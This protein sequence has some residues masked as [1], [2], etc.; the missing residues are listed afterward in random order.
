MK[1]NASVAKQASRLFDLDGTPDIVADFDREKGEEL[2][3]PKRSILPPSIMRF[4]R[5]NGTGFVPASVIVS[6]GR[7]ANQAACPGVSQNKTALEPDPSL[8]AP[9]RKISPRKSE[10]PSPVKADE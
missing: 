3:R 9:C 4:F 2:S 6:S 1:K 10:M 8:A 7:S 5:W